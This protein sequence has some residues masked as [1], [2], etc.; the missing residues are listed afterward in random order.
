MSDEKRLTL[1]GHLAELRK[2]LTRS[3][4][5]IAITTI[6]SFVFARQIFDI[7]TYQ[8]PFLKGIFAF[9]NYR[10]QL[11]TPPDINLVFIEI[12]EMIGVYF[13]VCLAS[14]IILAVPYLTYELIMFV[15]PA[16]PGP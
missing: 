13:R 1:L 6:L 3:V 10:F 14:G 4:L 12:T 8:S 9:L 15:A 2:R 16:S 5:V 7:L 11:L